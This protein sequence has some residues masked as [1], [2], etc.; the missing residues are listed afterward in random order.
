VTTWHS[1]SDENSANLILEYIIV[2]NDNLNKSNK[3]MVHW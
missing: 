3:V 1:A 2:D